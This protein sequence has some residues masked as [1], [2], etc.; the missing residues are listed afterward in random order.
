MPAVDPRSRDPP[1]SL[2][3]RLAARQG[4]HGRGLQSARHPPR[5]RGRDQGAARRVER[6]PAIQG[7][8][9]ARGEEDLP[10]SASQRLHALRRGLPGR[11][12]LPGH[13]VPPRGDRGEPSEKGSSADPGG[14]E[15]RE[16]DRRGDRGGSPARSRPPRPQARQRDLDG[17]AAPRSWTSA[18]RETRHLPGKRSTPRRRRSR[19]RS[20]RKARSPAPCRTWLRSSSKAGPRTPGPTSGPWA[21]SSTRWRPASVPSTA[22]P[23]RASPPPS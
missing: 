8:L 3:D 11:R 16:P 15:D 20:P 1:G 22:P 12:R 5:A 6:R 18:W 13:G 10:A 23:G 17:D 14:S 4:R 2:R 7:T 21:A 9:G 19:P